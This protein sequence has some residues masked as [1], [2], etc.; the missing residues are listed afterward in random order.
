MAYSPTIQNGR[1]THRRNAYFSDRLYR[2]SEL[3]QHPGRIRYREFC[4]LIWL[5]YA[6]VCGFHCAR[7]ILILVGYMDVNQLCGGG[8]S[9]YSCCWTVAWRVL[10][11][12]WVW[13]EQV[14]PWAIFCVVA[15]VLGE[16]LVGFR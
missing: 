10:D 11:V 14:V 12:I 3:I 2:V 16:A 8:Q 9:F 4:F 15:V 5:L 13:M 7:N 1:L 6:L